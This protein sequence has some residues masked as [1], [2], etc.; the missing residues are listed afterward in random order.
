MLRNGADVVSLSR[1]MGH[2][3]IGLLLRYAKQV[4]DDLRREHEQHGPV[5]GLL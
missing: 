4:E 3:G 1:L 2:E 5:D